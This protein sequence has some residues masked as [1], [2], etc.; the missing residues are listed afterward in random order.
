MIVAQTV[1]GLLTTVVCLAVSHN[2]AAAFVPE[3]VRRS[4]LSYVRISSGQA[5]SSAMET[6]MSSCT[7]A[8][9]HPDVPLLI[10]STKF[11][12]N[13]TLDLLIISKFHL[14]SFSPTVN[15]QALIR[16]ACDMSSA[17]SGL[18]YFMYIALK[19]RRQS[20]TLEESTKPR[21]R[22]YVFLRHP[23]KLERR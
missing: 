19:L 1:L 17:L 18:V 7:R 21:L 8:L 5:L 3:L 9:D 10:S 14:G 20:R 16:L 6:A 23:A 22:L 13:I 4:S 11:I 15:T 2:L 12:I